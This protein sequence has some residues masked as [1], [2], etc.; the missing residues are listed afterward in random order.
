MGGKIKIFIVGVGGQGSLTASR[1]LGEAALQAGENVVVSEVH[2]MAQRGGVV[3]TAVCLGNVRSPII[4]EG[5]ADCILGFEPLE[6]L[7]AMNKASR[8]TLVITNTRP[9][10][11]ITVSLKQSQY[12]EVKEILAEIEAFVGGR[13]LIALDAIEL[14]KEAGS[15]IAMNMVLLGALAATAILPFAVEALQQTIEQLAPRY[16]QLNLRAFQLGYNYVVEH[17]YG[18]G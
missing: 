13:K 8:H 5:E 18:Y 12:P 6:T 17:G 14:A 10:I 15:V 1:L 4:G 9:I 11:P 16:A 7:R 2:G 3:E